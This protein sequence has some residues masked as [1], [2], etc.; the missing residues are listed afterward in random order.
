M[1][2]TNY[3]SE[4]VPGFRDEVGQTVVE[5]DWVVLAVNNSGGLRLARV[6][7]IV[8]ERRTRV[9]RWVPK[10][11]EEW[12]E[13]ERRYSNTRVPQKAE[14]ETYTRAKITVTQYPDLRPKTKPI[15]RDATNYEMIKYT[16]PIPFDMS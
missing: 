9:A 4:P 2:M 1:D 3:I 8:G 12:S 6:L 13:W 5:G 16:G 14:E 15:R 11:E 10:P 7:E